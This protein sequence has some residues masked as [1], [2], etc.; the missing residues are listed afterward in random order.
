[1][2]VTRGLALFL[3]VA[4]AG[5]LRQRV[6]PGR[7]PTDVASVRLKTISARVDA[8]GRVARHRSDRAG[9]VRRDAA[10]IR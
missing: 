3:T 2:T 8:Q 5:A 7:R 9:G 4:A 10:R 1:M 6:R